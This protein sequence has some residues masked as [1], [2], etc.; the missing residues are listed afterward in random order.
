[1]QMG[2]IAPHLHLCNTPKK[3]IVVC[4]NAN[5]PSNT[6]PTNK[7]NNISMLPAES[8]ILKSLSQNHHNTQ[9]AVFTC[10]YILARRLLSHHQQ[11][12]YAQS[13]SQDAEQTNLSILWK[14]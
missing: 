3:P 4:I 11:V 5:Q 6:I 12:H 8:P 9:Q 2:G 10:F 14:K 13:G 1:M 7:S